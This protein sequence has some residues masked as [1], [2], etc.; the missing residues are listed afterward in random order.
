MMSREHFGQA[1]NLKCMPGY[2]SSSLGGITLA[3]LRSYEMKTHFDDIRLARGAGAQ[4]TTADKLLVI[5]SAHLP[6]LKAVSLLICDFLCQLLGNL[7]S[8]QTSA[9]IDERHHC[10]VTP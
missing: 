8:V 7:L 10:R 1:Q 3:P 4:T 5:S 9:P 2:A 6:I